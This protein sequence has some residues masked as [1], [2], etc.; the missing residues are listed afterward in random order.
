MSDVNEVNTYLV[1]LPMQIQGSTPQAAVDGF[2][3]ML[4]RY[5]LVAWSY[6]VTDLE[7][8]SRITV[9]QGQVIEEEEDEPA[10]AEVDPAP[11]DG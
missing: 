10:P 3:D 2:I 11:T 4:N 6:Q 1:N 8:Q 5:G 9:R 7:G